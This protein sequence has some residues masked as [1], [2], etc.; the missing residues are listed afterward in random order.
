MMT[1]MHIKKILYLNSDIN[2]WHASWSYVFI[3]D[4]N[5]I[6]MESFPL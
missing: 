1:P 6:K 4:R 3:D 5:I 2:K